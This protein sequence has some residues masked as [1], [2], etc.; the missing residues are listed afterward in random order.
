MAPRL[1]NHETVNRTTALPDGAGAVAVLGASDACR[2][3]QDFGFSSATAS[4]RLSPLRAS[5]D[6]IT[7]ITVCT[8]GQVEHQLRISPQVPPPQRMAAWFDE[9]AAADRAEAERAVTT[10]ASL[11]AVAAN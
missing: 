9:T 1:A 2:R 5:V 10:I 11:F 4:L 3:A 8:R 7:R 6:R